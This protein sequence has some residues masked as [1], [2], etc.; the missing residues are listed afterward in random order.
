VPRFSTAFGWLVSEAIEIR[1]FLTDCRWLRTEVRI[2][3]SDYIESVGC[4]VIM[5]RPGDNPM[6]AHFAALAQLEAESVYAFAQLARDLQRHD[7]P[8]HLVH[9]ATKAAQDELRHTYLS[10]R[11]AGLWGARALAPRRGRHT[12][13]DLFALC[14]DNAVEGCVYETF[15]AAVAT[16]QAETAQDPFVRSTMETIARDERRHAALADVVDRW[17]RRCL[18]PSQRDVVEA[19]AVDAARGLAASQHEAPECVS[20]LAGFPLAPR[21]R[22]MAS[23]LEAARRARRS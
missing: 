6:G 22:A 17:A 18:S 7:A 2:R 20:T 13:R 10:S 14:L 12:D 1:A 16:H 3:Y 9:A 15:G 8:F 19:A 11:L 5:V 4:S 21:A 23:E